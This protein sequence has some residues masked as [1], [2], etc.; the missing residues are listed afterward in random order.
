MWTGATLFY[1][2]HSVYK[3]TSDFQLG[4]NVARTLYKDTQLKC[5]ECEIDIAVLNGDILIVGNV[6]TQELRVEVQ[7]RIAQLA[8]YRRFFNQLSVG[9]ADYDSIQDSWITA[10]IRARIIA[11]ADINPNDFKVVT[12]N[13]IVYVMGDVRPVQAKKVILIARQTV[14]VRRVV[15]LL[16]YYNL[17]DQAI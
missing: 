10:K 7:K 15:K 2:R 14:G 3:K 13:K 9:L 12:S 5:Q 1:D 4:A 16:K 8:G 6:P 17:S 11:D